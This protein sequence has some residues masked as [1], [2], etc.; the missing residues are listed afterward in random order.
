LD[1]RRI[2]RRRGDRNCSIKHLCHLQHC[3]SRSWV[4]LETPQCYNHIPFYLLQIKNCFVI[5]LH[6]NINSAASVTVICP[7]SQDFLILFCHHGL[8]ISP[9]TDE[10][11][12]NDPIAVNI[13][14]GS[15]TNALEPLRGNISSGTTDPCICL[16]LISTEQFG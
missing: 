11:Q 3:W 10:L 7:V 12:Q 14:L 16:C 9:A 2:I 8:N 13:N 5:T 15:G 1:K 4:L 6:Q